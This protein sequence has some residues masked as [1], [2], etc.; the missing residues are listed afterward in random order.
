MKIFYGQTG[1]EEL[2]STTAVALFASFLSMP[3]QA[4]HDI[5][6][7]LD[8]KLQQYIET[9]PAGCRAAVI[10][11]PAYRR[12]AIAGLHAKLRP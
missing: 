12:R 8:L 2:K 6:L 7:T 1:Y 10:V 3:P 9:L 11:D 5:H 4:G